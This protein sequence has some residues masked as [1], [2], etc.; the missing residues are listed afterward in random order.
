M[1]DIFGSVVDTGALVA[2]SRQVGY[3]VSQYAGTVEE[4]YEDRHG[5]DKVRVR[6]SQTRF[7]VPDK[8]QVVQLDKVVVIREAGTD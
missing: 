4:A 6:Y 8:A 3:S 7:G 2:V 1:K 5:N